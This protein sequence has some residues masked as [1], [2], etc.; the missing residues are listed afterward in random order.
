MQE[1]SCGQHLHQQGVCTVD[2]A[3]CRRVLTHGQSGSPIDDDDN[4]LF[5]TFLFC[6]L[7]E[8]AYVARD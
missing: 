2:T 1:E 5:I 7:C 8:W 3:V 6:M 4:L